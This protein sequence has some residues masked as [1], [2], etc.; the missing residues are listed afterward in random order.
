MPLYSQQLP[1]ENCIYKMQAKR[2]KVFESQDVEAGHF[3]V[4]FE[5]EGRK[6]HAHKMFLTSVSEPLDAWLSTRWTKKDEVIKIS[7][8]SFNDFY[9][10][11]HFLYTGDCKITE[12]NVFALT[13]MAEFYGIEYLKGFCDIFLSVTKSLL[14]AANVYNWAENRVKKEKADDATNFNL[15]EAIKAE[16]STI[17]PLEKGFLLSPAEMYRIFKIREE[18]FK[19]VV[20]LAER[21]AL[22]KQEM[23][24]DTASFDLVDSVKADLACV[25]PHVKFYEMDKSFLTNFV[26]A[27]G[28]ISEYQA[29]HVYDTRGKP[30]F[31]DYA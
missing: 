11:L 24:S 10:F 5:L 23:S 4:T 18:P 7:D 20:E 21:Q 3:D 12:D 2:F 27:K 15:L 28:I 25:V 30:V 31:W 8:Y 1:P 17:L 9:E 16:L 6:L 13:D 14:E 26:A 19:T 22:K 29:N